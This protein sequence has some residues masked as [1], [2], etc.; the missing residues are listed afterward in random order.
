MTLP[1]LLLTGILELSIKQTPD[2]SLFTISNTSNAN[3]G[4]TNDCPLNGA[5]SNNTTLL[6]CSSFFS[7]LNKRTLSISSPD[8][9]TTGSKGT[10][11]GLGYPPKT[12]NRIV[13]L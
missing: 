8:N 9:L 13:L 2:T 5:H 12:L 7:I 11:T 3:W 10:V 6:Y 4:V 1:A